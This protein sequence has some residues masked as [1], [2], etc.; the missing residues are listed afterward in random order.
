[1]SGTRNK[2]AL[3]YNGEKLESIDLPTEI[4]DDFAHPLAEALDDFIQRIDDLHDAVFTMVPQ[5]SNLM[6][7]RFNRALK[8]IKDAESKIKSGTPAESSHA[9]AKIIDAGYEIESLA[10]SRQPEAIERNLFVGMFSEFDQFMGI[11]IRVLYKKRPDLLK[12]IS[13]SITLSELLKFDDIESA[14]SSLLEGE[15]ESIRREGYIDQFSTLKNRFE[16]TLTDFED[17]PKF[18][19]SSQRRNLMVHCGGIVSSQYV[20]VCKSVGYKFSSQPLIGSELKLGPDYFSDASRVIIKVAFMLTHTLWRKVLTGE[21]KSANEQLNNQ[22]Y[23]LLCSKRWRIAEEL[24]NFSLT[25]PMRAGANDVQI[26]IR[27]C[28]TAIA[29]KNLSKTNE[30]NEILK[31]ADW[32]ASIRDFR[33]AVAILN[34]DFDKAASLM[35]EIGKR[36]EL[37]H[38]V[39]YHQWPLFASFRE[40]NEFHLAYEKIYGYPFYLKAERAA[41]IAREHVEGRTDP[42]AKPTTVKKGNNPQKSGKGATPSK[43]PSRK[44]AKPST[45]A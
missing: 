34:D 13:R 27:I 32:T 9:G 41:D 40:R 17:W 36:G 33:L 25:K 3:V 38:E 24:G 2:K 21:H 6:V 18:I 30:M 10:R 43:S 4:A 45:G 14:K 23:R 7:K 42:E 39:S 29:L 8:T 12:S 44:A 26:R 28:N 37:I 22:I 20:Q 15:I 16:V 11:L 1:M 31:S 19:E 5:A 35:A